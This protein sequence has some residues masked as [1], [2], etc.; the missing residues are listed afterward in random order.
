MGA[1]GDLTCSYCYVTYY[2]LDEHECDIA[3]LKNRID[4]L[5]AELE[6]EDV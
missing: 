3:D 5:E 2:E 1:Y 4:M 6:T